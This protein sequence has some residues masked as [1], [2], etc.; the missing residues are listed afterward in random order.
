MA[1]SELCV[2]KHVHTHAAALASPTF[3]FPLP[4]HTH[5]NQHTGAPGSHL[6][7]TLIP[8]PLRNC[9]HSHPQ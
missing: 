5:P 7:L 9:P 1:D 8:E 6:G 4:L 2:T 3:S